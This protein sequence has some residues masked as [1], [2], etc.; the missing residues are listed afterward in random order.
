MTNVT[1]HSSASTGHL[2]TA[3]LFEGRRGAFG[4]C[5]DERFGHFFFRL[6]ANLRFVVTLDVVARV[7][8]IHVLLP[9]H[10]TQMT[11]LFGA[12]RASEMLLGDGDETREI[13]GRTLMQLFV[14]GGCRP[15]E[16]RRQHLLLLSLDE[17]LHRL[18]IDEAQIDGGESS[19]AIGAETRHGDVPGAVQNR[20]D[21][22]FEA[23]VTE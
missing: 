17:T 15:A 3:T 13:A 23:F 4:T 12:L 9:V 16:R 19:R 8:V 1:H 18:V 2:V 10:V 11:S 7:A 14:D 5:T 22:I 20:L 6:Q 21:V